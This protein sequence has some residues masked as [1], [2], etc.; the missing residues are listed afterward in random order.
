VSTGKAWGDSRPQAY[1]RSHP[2]TGDCSGCHT[3]S[4]T[5]ATNQSGTAAK[6]ANHIPTN[7]ACGQCHTTAGNYGAYVMGATGHAGITNNCAQCHAYGLSFYNMAS[8]TLKQP[9]SGKTGHIPG[10]PPNGTTSIACELCHLPTAFTTFAGTVMKHAYVTSMQ[11]MSCHEFNMTW[12]VNAGVQLWTRPSPNHFKG[13]DCGS[14]GCHTSRD[15]LAVRL[16]PRPTATTP[17]RPTSGSTG[18]T[19]TGTPPTPRT[20]TTTPALAGTQSGTSP[21]AAVTA[22]ATAAPFNHASVA[23]TPCVSCHTAASGAGKPSTHMATTDACQSCHTTIA[24]LPVR[25]VDHTQVIGTCVSCHDGHTAIGKPARHIATTASCDSCHTTNAWTP[26]R[27]DHGAI[28]AH[29]CSSCHNSVQATGKPVTHIPTTQQCDACHGTLGWKPVKVDHT[30][31]T[32]GCAACHNNAGA[33]GQPPGHLVTRL[34]CSTCHSYPDWSLMH[35]RHASAAYPGNH[36][37]ALACASC[38]TSNTEA[39]PYPAPAYAGTC[40]GCHAKDFRPAAHPK[41]VKGVTYIVSELANCSGACHVYSDTTQS[42]ITR[43][44][45]GPYHRVSDAAFKH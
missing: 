29:T 32:T 13:K 6:P 41:T 17:T 12:Q 36:R 5:F 40:A 11:C 3:T 4:P 33:A 20:G 34:D 24:W 35:F 44:L 37:T 27:F 30:G 10:V 22:P 23:G 38:H 18:T 43:S 9:A 42:T 7:A 28:A 16:V 8:P 31:F 19:R 2:S 25:T 1:D 39:V 21:S 15:R 14:S 26:A 45:P